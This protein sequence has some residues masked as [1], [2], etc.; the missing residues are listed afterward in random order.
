MAA[1]G[2][3]L[4]QVVQQRIGKEEEERPPEEKKVKM[5]DALAELEKLPRKDGEWVKGEVRELG[6]TREK[7][8]KRPNKR[9]FLIEEA[10]DEM[11]KQLFEEKLKLEENE[12]I[13]QFPEEIQKE[14]RKEVI[15]MLMD[16]RGAFSGG[17]EGN[18]FAEQ[19][20]QCDWFEYQLVLKPAYRD[21]IFYQKPKAL[22]REYTEALRSLL[23]DWAGK[24]LIRKNNP[25][26]DKEGSPHSLPMFLVK[27]KT[28]SGS[29][30]AHRGILDARRLNSASIHR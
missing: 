24:G 9:K 7:E 11:V 27:K 3:R 14:M 20:R 22:S 30:V 4:G 23:E 25:T 12:Y 1:E 16:Q 17:E 28:A 18:N 19:I 13:R 29:G 15:A 26:K 8:I 2:R 5:R 21:T 6:D 10:P